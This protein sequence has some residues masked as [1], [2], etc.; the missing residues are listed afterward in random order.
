MELLFVAIPTVALL[1]WVYYT[2]VYVSP[3]EKE[4][5]AAYLARYKRWCVAEWEHRVKPAICLNCRH[6]SRPDRACHRMPQS[7]RKP[8]DHWCGEFNRTTLVPKEEA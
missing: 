6:Y 5:E 4:A 7:D 1:A 8:A 2:F 3:K